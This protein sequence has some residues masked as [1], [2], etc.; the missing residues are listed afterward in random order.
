MKI[1]I[2]YVD[3]IQS[4]TQNFETGKKYPWIFC[5]NED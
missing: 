4:E 5:A 2:F 3:S 1:E